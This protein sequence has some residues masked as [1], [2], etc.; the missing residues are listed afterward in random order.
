MGA[1]SVI[2]QTPGQPSGQPSNQPS[3]WKLAPPHDKQ[4]QG[5]VV[6]GFVDLPSAQA[7]FLMPALVPVE[8][9]LLPRCLRGQ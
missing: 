8:L 3:S 9:R 6:S 2:G 7:L 4:T 5:I 1:G